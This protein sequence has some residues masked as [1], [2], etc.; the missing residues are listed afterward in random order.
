MVVDMD[1]SREVVAHNTTDHPMGGETIVWIV[2]ST[3]IG[4]IRDPPHGGLVDGTGSGLWTYRGVVKDDLVAD[5]Q[6]AVATEAPPS[7][8]QVGPQRA[9]TD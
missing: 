9:S 6:Q 7:L 4:S 5:H 2:T 1:T 3:V 8:R